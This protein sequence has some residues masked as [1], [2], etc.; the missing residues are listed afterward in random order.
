M[1]IRLSITVSHPGLFG[2]IDLNKVSLDSGCIDDPAAPTGC[3]MDS[4]KLDTIRGT[5][6]RFNYPALAG[7]DYVGLNWQEPET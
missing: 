5:V 1:Q 2:T 7:S 4:T 3:S 6:F